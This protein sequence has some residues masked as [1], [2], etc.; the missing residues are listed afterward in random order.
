M[1]GAF[2]INLPEKASE[3]VNNADAWLT[4]QRALLHKESMDFVQHIKTVSSWAVIQLKCG[5]SQYSF[6]YY[7]KKASMLKSWEHQ[8]QDKL[9]QIRAP[10]LIAELTFT[11][12]I[13]HQKVRTAHFE[14]WTNWSS[15]YENDLSKVKLPVKSSIT[16]IRTQSISKALFSLPPQCYKPVSRPGRPPL[17]LWTCCLVF[18]SLPLLLFFQSTRSSIHASTALLSSDDLR[19]LPH[20]HNWIIL[21]ASH[22]SWPCWVLRVHRFLL[23][24]PSCE[25]ELPCEVISCWPHALPTCG[26]CLSMLFLESL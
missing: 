18:L 4:L 16:G 11:K 17:P 20:S 10:S 1:L 2:K 19:L 7:P 6:S 23:H 24:L 15:D 13:L 12:C 3:Q 9:V 8:N 21:P 14:R 25:S 5:S 26:I 22:T